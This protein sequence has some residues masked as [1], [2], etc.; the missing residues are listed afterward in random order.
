MGRIIHN[1]DVLIQTGYLVWVE[2]DDEGYILDF[3]IYTFS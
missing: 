3:N 1:Q 2:D